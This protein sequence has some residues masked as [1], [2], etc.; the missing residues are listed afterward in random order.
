MACNIIVVRIF[1][2]RSSIASGE[3]SMTGAGS[4]CFRTEAVTGWLLV[5]L[6]IAFSSCPTNPFGATGCGCRVLRGFIACLFTCSAV[7]A[8][9]FAAE[10]VALVRPVFDFVRVREFFR[11]PEF[12]ASS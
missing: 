6:E 9:A 8:N 4:V 10:R 12:I 5:P 1:C 3:N 7:L 11:C 2:C